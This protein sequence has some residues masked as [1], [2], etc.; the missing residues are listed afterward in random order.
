MRGLQFLPT[1]EPQTE[2]PL[3]LPLKKADNN[4][5]LK[6]GAFLFCPDL[7]SPLPATTKSFLTSHWLPPAHPAGSYSVESAG[8]SAWPSGDRLPR[9]EVLP[10]LSPW[11]R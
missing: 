3:Q 6:T 7:S 1:P 2:S 9:Q 5:R 8:R 11:N 10:R 4:E